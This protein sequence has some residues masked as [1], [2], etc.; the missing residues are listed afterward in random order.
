VSS[1]FRAVILL[2]QNF[3]NVDQFAIIL[4]VYSPINS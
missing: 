1:S 2:A 3:A 4:K